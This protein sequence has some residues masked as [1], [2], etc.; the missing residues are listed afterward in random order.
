MCI[1]DKEAL[2]KRVN[3]LIDEVYQPQLSDE[4]RIQKA[5]EAT[6]LILRAAGFSKPE[7]DEISSCLTK[8]DDP[9]HQQRVI[10]A[11]SDR[12]DRVG[13]IVNLAN[14]VSPRSA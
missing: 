4:L 9:A 3:D 6:D 11:V 13:D 7:R 1:A 5:K 14:L 10:R 12:S 8:R 2:K